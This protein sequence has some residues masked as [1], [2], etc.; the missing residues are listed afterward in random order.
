MKSFKTGLKSV[1]ILAFS[2][3]TVGSSFSQSVGIGTITPNA[4]SIIDIT[5][6]D[7]ATAPQGMLLPRLTTAQRTSLGGVLGS[8]DEGM[9]VYDTGNDNVYKWDGTVW[10]SIG[11]TDSDWTTGTGVVY[12]TTAQVGIGTSTPVGPFHVAIDQDGTPDS[13]FIV[14]GAG[15]VG[16]GAIPSGTWKIEI[17]GNIG[18]VGINELSDAR[19]KMNVTPLENSLDKV[20]RL[21][22][23]T[24]DWKVD[25]FPEKGFET[26]TQ[27][28]FIAQDI[29]KVIPE[30]VD[31]DA[32]GYKSVEYSKLVS[33]LTGAV[34]EQQATIERL[35]A[36]I[37]NMQGD[38]SELEVLKKDIEILKEILGSE[39]KAVD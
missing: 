30:L 37:A 6:P 22:S 36:Q 13:L 4:N 39:S 15:N 17:N 38:L 32:N 35:E 2:I 31:T 11:G 34:Q 16:V 23:V 3:V 12:N 5:V 27:I 14:D 8:T 10:T 20:M 19:W 18:T 25:E 33:V 28:G 29:E 7:P 26:G 9:I 21:Q 1:L 24:Y